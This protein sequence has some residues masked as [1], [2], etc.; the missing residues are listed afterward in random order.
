[1]Y[2]CWK[3]RHV[4]SVHTVLYS[5]TCLCLETSAVPAVLLFVCTMSYCTLCGDLPIHTSGGLDLLVGREVGM[6]WQ[7]QLDAVAGNVREL[8]SSKSA[9]DRRVLLALLT[10]AAR[11]TPHHK[12]PSV[13]Y[14]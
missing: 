6:A 8:I 9:R 13:L 4:W 3:F 5:S 10:N 11:T 2:A 1:M 7:S 14:A 12:V